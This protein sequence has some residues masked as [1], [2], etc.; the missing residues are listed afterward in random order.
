M[1]ARAPISPPP[2]SMDDRG[3]FLS[4][5]SGLVAAIARITLPKYYTYTC[6]YAHA[7]VRTRA[8]AGVCVFTSFGKL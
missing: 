5:D 7:N 6:C 8:R 4:K 2:F 1:Y 3:N